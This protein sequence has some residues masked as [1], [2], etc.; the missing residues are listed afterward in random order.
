M[1]GEPIHSFACH[2]DYC[3]KLT[4][5]LMIAAAVFRE[6]DVIETSQDT[7]VFQ[8]FEKFPNGKRFFCSTCG[9]GVHWINPDVFPG[10]RLIAIGAFADREFPGPEIVYQT[11]YRHPWQ[12]PIECAM[13][14]T[15][16]P[17]ESDA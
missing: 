3:Q 13:S 10:M 11:Q 4:G 16:Y 5:S 8:G 12:G 2:C 14:F 9:A 6:E 15:A 7:A 1:D 17:V